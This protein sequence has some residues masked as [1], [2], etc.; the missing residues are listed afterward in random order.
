MI[1][2][3]KV[4]MKQLKERLIGEFLPFWEGEGAGLRTMNN[5]INN[6]KTIFEIKSQ[7]SYGS[8][9]LSHNR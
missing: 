6:G 7:M 8:I 2:K 1:V 9:I 5:K 3:V 4:G